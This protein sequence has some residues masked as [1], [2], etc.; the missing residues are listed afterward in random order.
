MQVISTTPV[1]YMPRSDPTLII[2][3][4]PVSVAL[5]VLFGADY[6]GISIGYIV[7][8]AYGMTFFTMMTS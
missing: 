1:R 4:I 7:V 6:L 2:E 5:G 3:R 8:L